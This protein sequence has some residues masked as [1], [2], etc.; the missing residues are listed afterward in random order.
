[1]R[2]PGDIDVRLAWAVWRRN[3]TQYRHTWLLNIF[4]NFFEPLLFLV[5]MGIGLG[6]Y[7]H[8][9]ADRPY[10]EIIAPGLLAAAAMNGATF[11]TTYNIFVK[12]N[13]AGVYDAYLCTPAQIQDIAFGELL[14]AMTR[15]LLYGVGF[16]VILGGLTLAGWHILESP[17]ALALPLAVLLIGGLFGLCGELFTALARVIDLYGYYYTLWLTPLF[18]F[19]GIFF[20]LDQLPLGAQIAWCTPLYH[21]VRLCRALCSGRMD[22]AAWTSLAWML[23]A[24]AVLQWLVPRALRR[25]VVQ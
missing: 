11:E 9:H 13:F 14:W 4:P 23:V 5:G 18:L 21:G 2:L 10:V 19:S 20:P 6:T 8:M 17:W 1:M 22:G 3:A 7:V 12:M 16:L 25:R 24:C 15:A